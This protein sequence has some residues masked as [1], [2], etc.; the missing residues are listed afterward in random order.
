MQK[1]K[2]VNRLYF[3]DFLYFSL[4]NF[5]GIYG[6]DIDELIEI[7]NLNK[8]DVIL[9]KKF[10]KFCEIQKNDHRNYENR[11]IAGVSFFYNTFQNSQLYL[12]FD[13]K[14]KSVPF[15]GKFEMF[16]K[17]LDD[18]ING[19]EGGYVTGSF[20]KDHISEMVCPVPFYSITHKIKI[21]ADKLLSIFLPADFSKFNEEKKIIANSRTS[22]TLGAVLLGKFNSEENQ[23]VYVLKESPYSEINWGKTYRIQ[24]TNNNFKNYIYEEMIIL[25]KKEVNNLKT[26]KEKLN[27]ENFINAP[28]CCSDFINQVFLVRRSYALNLNGQ[29]IDSYLE[30]K[31]EE[32]LDP[33]KIIMQIRE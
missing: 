1:K 11:N 32:I 22:N 30:L 21:P 25:S 2:Q 18:R 33:H 6:Y 20:L 19:L 13:I 3:E 8:K 9:L 14:E 28:K 17:I 27:L 12:P 16:L 26:P 10:S 4:M 31:E 5:F 15:P 7:Y 23:E 24:I 29:L